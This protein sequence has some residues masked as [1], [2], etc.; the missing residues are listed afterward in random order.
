MDDVQQ[1]FET[2]LESE[3]GDSMTYKEFRH[4]LEVLR[5]CKNPFELLLFL[6][7]RRKNELKRNK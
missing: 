2:M 5:A 3:K 7:F 6:E 1:A 4:N